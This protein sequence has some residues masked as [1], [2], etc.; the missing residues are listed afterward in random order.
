MEEGDRQGKAGGGYRAGMADR[1][2]WGRWVVLDAGTRH[3]VK[4]ITV[5]PGAILSLQ[6]HERRDEHWVVVE[7]NARVT[8]GDEVFELPENGSTF[9]PRGVPHR[10][11]N[12]G[13]GELRFI[14]VQ[15]GDQPREDDIVRLEDAYGRA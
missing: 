14:E 13:E 3:A 2:P 12:I 1:R 15:F 9:I 8:L 7:G 10:M 6:V 11:E 5:K 4:L